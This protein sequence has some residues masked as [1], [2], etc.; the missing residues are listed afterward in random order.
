MNRGYGKT[1]QLIKK[2]AEAYEKGNNLVIAG[3]NIMECTRILNMAE[4]MG[5]KIPTPLTFREII[6]KSYLGKQKVDALMIDNLDMFI[7]YITLPVPLLAVTLSP[8]DK[9][10]TYYK[11]TL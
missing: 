1:Y 6:N 10:M 2:S 3:H 4:E 7:E 8:E 9:F 5:V 11:S